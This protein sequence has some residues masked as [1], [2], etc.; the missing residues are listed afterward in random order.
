VSQETARPAWRGILN[1]LP[2]LAFSLLAIWI[3]SRVVTWDQVVGALEHV[4]PWRL[5]PVIAL[6]FMGMG[7]RT[8]AW[9]TILQRKAS[10]KQVF[11]ALNEGYLLNNIFPLRLGEFGR[12]VLLGRS[13]KLGVLPV[14]SSIVVERSYDLAIS[15]GM[16]L[17]TLPLAL[18]MDWARPLAW[19]ILVLVIAG[20]VGLALAARYRAGL[21]GAARRRSLERSKLGGWVLPKVESLLGGF[22]ALTDFRLFAVSLGLMLL[23]WSCSVGEDWFLL[24]GFVSHP[25]VWWVVFV[26]GV[27][28]LGGALPSSAGAVGVLEAAIVTALVVLNVNQSTALAYGIVLHVIHYSLSSVLGMV[29]LA[30]EGESLGGIYRELHTRRSTSG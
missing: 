9:R 20:L 2:G 8:L 7:L 5:V 1:W 18:N 17:V 15:A 16:L 3:L 22:G 23:S 14:L 27:T 21:I 10:V 4:E 12:A 26:L 28:A 29:G 13:S 6:Y 30:R 25:P 19:G 24:S 11:F